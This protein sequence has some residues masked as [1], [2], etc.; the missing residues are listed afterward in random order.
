MDSTTSSESTRTT[1]AF[2]STVTVT[3]T[4]KSTHL[5]TATANVF[6]RNCPATIVSNKIQPVSLNKVYTKSTAGI[7]GYSSLPSH[8]G[9]SSSN[10]QSGNGIHTARTTDSTRL[11]SSSHFKRGNLSI[12]GPNDADSKSEL[13]SFPCSTPVEITTL[14]RVIAT[15][16]S[17]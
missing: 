7:L 9:I 3:N 13:T 17:S 5:A 15:R 16:T 2:L 8:D 12:R 6:E 14:A 10:G 4:I 11:G 1:T